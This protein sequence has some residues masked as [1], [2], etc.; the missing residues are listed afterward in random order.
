[1]VAAAP[2]AAGHRHSHLAEL[3]GTRAADVAFD[4]TDLER[5]RSRRQDLIDD[6]GIKQRP[7]YSA[8]DH[9]RRRRRFVPPAPFGG[10]R[11]EVERR[12][13][14]ASRIGVQPFVDPARRPRTK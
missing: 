6:D 5:D 13:L 14:R 1:M 11:R 8:L 7:E 3:L 10:K 2:G 4:I 9:R 12:H